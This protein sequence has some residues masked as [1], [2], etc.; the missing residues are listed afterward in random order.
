MKL[1]RGRDLPSSINTGAVATIGNFDGVH[2]GHQALLSRLRAEAKAR[3]LPLLVI[4]F[5]PQPGEYFLQERAPARLSLLRDK[6]VALKR[7]GVDYVYC[8][9]FNQKMAEIDAAQFAQDTFFSRFF[10]KYILVGE[11]FRFGRDRM[12]DVG[13]LQLL[14]KD[15]GATVEAFPNFVIDHERV[16]S[17]TIRQALKRG[18]FDVAKDLLGRPYAILGRI[19]RGDGRGRQWGVPTANLHLRHKAL[20]L[21]GVFCVKM[22]RPWGQV[23]MG[24]ANMG[25]RPTVDG[26]KKCL[27]IYLFDFSGDLY[28]EQV[29]VIFLH[30][31]RD[32][33]KFPSVND[34]IRAIQN[35]VEM[36]KQFCMTLTERVSSNG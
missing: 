26:V 20:P 14:A 35:D 16:S 22:I 11:D 18:A 27:E 7:F 29:Q 19:V 17:T 2:L 33:I 34:L 31:L 24:V 8:I 1:L 10:V 12:G 6:L 15:A 3:G 9:R 5:E 28:G 32:E 23:M 13:L 36:A 21:S 25:C 30:K 4:L